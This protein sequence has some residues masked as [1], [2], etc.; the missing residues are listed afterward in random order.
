[1]PQEEMIKRKKDEEEEYEGKMLVK[2]LMRLNL[3]YIRS[4]L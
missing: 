1:V 4:L 2:L 3:V